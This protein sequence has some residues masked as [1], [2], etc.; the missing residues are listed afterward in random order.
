MLF[1]IGSCDFAAYRAFET[2]QKDRPRDGAG[3]FK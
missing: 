3:G 2:V 1:G